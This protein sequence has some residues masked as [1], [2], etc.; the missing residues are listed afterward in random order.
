MPQTITERAVIFNSAVIRLNSLVVFSLPLLAFFFSQHYS[1]L[2]FQCL[3][4][5]EV[6]LLGLPEQITVDTEID[7]LFRGSRI[8]KIGLHNGLLM[9]I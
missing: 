3:R 8:E 4:Q 6:A 1:K 2:H 7:W 5:I 9:R